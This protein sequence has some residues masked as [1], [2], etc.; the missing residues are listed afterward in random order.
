MIT[1]AISSAARLTLAPAK[2]AGQLTGALLRGL[3]GNDSRAT[4]SAGAKPARRSRAQAQPKRSGTRSSGKRQTKRTP[5]RARPKR[6]PSSARPAKRPTARTSAQA[7]PKH[8]ERAEPLSDVAI[9]REVES[10]IFR[11]I[12][13]DRG[14]VDVNVAEGVVRLRGE[15]PTPDLI[16]E[17][18]GRAARVPKVRRVENL[19]RTPAPPPEPATPVTQHAERPGAPPPEIAG[20]ARTTRTGRWGDKAEP[21]TGAP[22]GVLEPAGRP[23]RGESADQDEPGTTEPDEERPHEPRE[24]GPQRTRRSRRRRARRPSAAPAAPPQLT[25]CF[26]SAAIFFSSAAVSSFSA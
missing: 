2:L 21:P 9:A 19:L 22:E 1:S 12:D 8:A 10:S 13:A 4:R 25:A 6:Q 17:L 20:G 16:K 3:R 26:T 7:R 15:V 11:D 24:P 5:A 23:Q 18:E 14:Q